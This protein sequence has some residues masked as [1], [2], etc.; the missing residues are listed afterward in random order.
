MLS[1]VV[2]I[3]GILLLGIL[4]GACRRGSDSD[5][6]PEPC[7]LAA[8]DLPPGWRIMSSSEMPPIDKTPWWLQNPQLLEGDEAQALFADDRP[9]N[10]ARVWAS[11]YAEGDDGDGRVLVFCLTY[12]SRNDAEAGY[13]LLRGESS[14]EGGQ[15]NLVGF[16]R[17]DQN[18]V[19]VVS[20]DTDVSSSDRDVFERYFHSVTAPL[21][22]DVG[23]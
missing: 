14:A 12:P 8:Q 21:R 15:I 13:E 10:A 23:R 19:V 20:I 4:A 17:K 6:A 9:S 7:L 3:T 11:I 16:L 2:T 22:L 1:R 5:T 18:T